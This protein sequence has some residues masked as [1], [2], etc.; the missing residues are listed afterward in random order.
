MSAVVVFVEQVKGAARRASVEALGAAAASGKQVIA[1]VTGPG[2]VE[3]AAGLGAS[4]AA[5]AFALTG[6]GAEQYSPDGTATDVA[7]IVKETSA[8]ACLAAATSAGKD[9]MP[10]VAAL[11]DS[12]LFSD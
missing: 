2:A 6:T 4:G 10:R 12:T 7:A 11:L 9:L 1:V 8:T 3:C 5:R